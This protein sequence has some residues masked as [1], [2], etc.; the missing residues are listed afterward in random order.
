MYWMKLRI[1]G[2]V[3]VLCCDDLCNVDRSCTFVRAK[4]SMSSPTPRN[5][6]HIS[7]V[8]RGN[9]RR[10]PYSEV[11]A[12]D[13]RHVHDIK[14]R[15]HHIGYLWISIPYSCTLLLLQAISKFWRRL[16][17]SKL[18]NVHALE[19][20]MGTYVCRFICSTSPCFL[21]SNRPRPSRGFVVRL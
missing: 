11:A 19:V 3:I 13:Q 12:F 2:I 14:K 5:P 15:L 10:P 18:V 17:T 4:P 20:G 8:W 21:S 9:K 16:I 1:L 7:G 6:G